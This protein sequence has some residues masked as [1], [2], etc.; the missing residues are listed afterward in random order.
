[1]KCMELEVQLGAPATIA[2]TSPLISGVN[3]VCSMCITR[4][5]ANVVPMGY[6]NKEHHIQP[7]FAFFTS[8]IISISVFWKTDSKRICRKPMDSFN[9][10]CR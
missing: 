7:L 10:L 6:R 3:D 5:C 8:N 2:G 9:S 1:M 4:V